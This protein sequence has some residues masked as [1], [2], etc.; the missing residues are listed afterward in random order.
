MTQIQ[1]CGTKYD[2]DK[3]RWD[4][5][6]YGA[7]EEIVQVFEY[8]AAKYGEGNWRLGFQKSRLFSATMRHL[9]ADWRGKYADP[10]S[11]LPHLAHAACNILFMLDLFMEG[12]R[13]MALGEDI[14]LHAKD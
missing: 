8:G 11:G 4:L 2:Q 10:E 1:K 14:P 7:I 9:L 3:R 5:L 13:K 6:P 12:E